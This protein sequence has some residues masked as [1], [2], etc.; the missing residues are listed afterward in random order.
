MFVR[1][2][3][4]SLLC[5]VLTS[6]TRLRL[7]LL[8]LT[9]LFIQHYNGTHPHFG[10]L[11]KRHDGIN[12]QLPFSTT[13]TTRPARVSWVWLSEQQTASYAH[14]NKQNFCIIASSLCLQLFSSMLLLLFPVT[15]N[16]RLTVILFSFSSYFQWNSHNKVPSVPLTLTIHY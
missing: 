3:V 13:S 8:R 5:S 6:F 11:N 16:T 15:F 2:C 7:L 10:A 12:I 14:R 4:W 9:S 1:S